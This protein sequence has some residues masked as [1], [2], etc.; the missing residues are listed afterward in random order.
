MMSMRSV[1]RFVRFQ[2]V[3]AK[4]VHT[5]A[6]SPCCTPSAVTAAESRR[7]TIE[8]RR[9]VT[10]SDYRVMA[11]AVS[12]RGAAVTGKAAGFCGGDSPR[13]KGIRVSGGGSQGPRRCPPDGEGSHESTASLSVGRAIWGSHAHHI[14][15]LVTRRSHAHGFGCSARPRRRNRAESGGDRMLITSHAHN[16]PITCARRRLPSARD[17]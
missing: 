11:A 16:T 1:C 8:S 9:R 4:R 14:M 13:I 7:V 10:A 5:R 6:R 3:K 15:V 12:R 17:P 2:H